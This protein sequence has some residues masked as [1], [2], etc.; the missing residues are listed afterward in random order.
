MD[1]HPTSGTDSRLRAAFEHAPTG[2]AL[3]DPDTHRVLEV[4]RVACEILGRSE[5]ELLDGAFPSE[6]LLEDGRG[7]ARIT[8][9]DGRSIWAD[10]RL[11]SHGVCLF[12]DATARREAHEDLRRSEE[13]L[14]TMVQTS[15]EGIWILGPD[16]LTTFVNARMAEM[17]GC[18][19]DEM[20]GRPTTDFLDDDEARKVVTLLAGRRRGM[21]DQYELKWRAPDGREVW[22]IMNASP[23]F[24]PD[25]SYAGAF[26]MATDISE[27]VWQERAV[28]ASEERYRNIIE[29]TTE[30]V[31]M[32][33][34]EHR[35]TYVNRRMAQMLGYRVEEMLGRPV[36]DFMPDGDVAGLGHDPGGAGGRPREVRYVRKDGSGMWGLLSGSPLADAAGGYGGALAM[37]ADITERKRSEESVARLAAIVESS[38]DAIFSTDLEGKITSWNSAAERIYGYTEEEVLGQTGWMLVLPE[39]LDEAREVGRTM[40]SGGSVIDFPSKART[41]DGRKIDIAPSVSA[42]R[43]HAGEVVGTLTIV[44]EI[45]P[46]D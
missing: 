29:T 1:R 17:L 7:E 41:K 36:S 24:D 40:L 38:P 18:T 8:R 12:D 39:R 31:W 15:H 2:I 16:D 19:V 3:F 45:A 33:D 21:A 14:R 5:Q 35:T 27:R 13:R 34:G 44:R 4:N 42:I 32:I 28:R 43:S 10:V 9:G 6:L 30:G 23:L 37:I 26:A 46:T 20:L 25:G 22:T 11:S